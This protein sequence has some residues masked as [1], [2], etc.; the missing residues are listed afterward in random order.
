MISIDMLTCGRELKA[1]EEEQWAVG[2]LIDRS[3]QVL[4]K[5]LEWNIV[6]TYLHGTW[7]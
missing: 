6:L 2:R 7:T 1:G 3:V 4:L 5:W